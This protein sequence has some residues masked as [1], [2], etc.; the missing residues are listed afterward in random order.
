VIAVFLR[1]LDALFEFFASLKLAVFV[2]LSFA[3]SLAA[4]TILES[5]YDTATSQYYVYRSVWFFGLLGLLGVNIFFAAMSRYPWKP[6]HTPFILAHIGIELLLIGSWV[7]HRYGLDGSIR[8]SEGETTGVVETDQLQ[9]LV[10]EK[11]SVFAFPIQWIPPQVAFHPF[12]VKAD[13]FPVELKVD[14]FLSHADAVYSFVPAGEPAVKPVAPKPAVQVVVSGGPMR[15]VQDFWLWTGEAAFQNIQAG[16]A[17]LLL[18]SETE[19]AKLS[20]DG[21]PMFIV[22]PGKDGSVSFR[23]FSSEKK[24]IEGRLPAGK[25]QGAA[26]N[27]GWKNVKIEIKSWLPDAVPNTRYQASRIKYGPQAPPSALHV[28]AGAG[29]EGSEVWLG[30]GD[31]AVLRYSGRTMEIGYFAHRVVLPYAVRLEKFEIERYEGSMNPASYSSRVSV[32]DGAGSPPETTISMN[33]PLDYRGTTLYQASYEDAKP[34]PVTS[35]FSVNR[36]PGRGT[37]YLGSLL[38]VLG[39]ILLFARKYAVWKIFDK[40]TK[41]AATARV[42]REVT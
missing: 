25:I 24:I 27:P 32:V 26:I 8:V 20:P 36:D 38:I 17:R 7:T 29:G 2:L 33:E 13:G 15:I 12:G 31:R 4:G 35:I 18:V 19:A 37:K 3:F 10:S 34:R 1:F 22:S 30:L 14:Q 16:P 40:K 42:S 28:V 23:S 21:K 41:P 5:M 11:G 6:R 39:T 9:L